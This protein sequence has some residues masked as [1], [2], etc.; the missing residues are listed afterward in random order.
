F[1][2]NG[3][4]NGDYN[5][6]GTDFSFSTGGEHNQVGEPVFVKV[7]STTDETTVGREYDASAWNLALRVASPAINAGENAFA[8]DA[9]GNPLVL[10]PRFYADGTVDIGAHEYQGAAVSIPA[11]PVGAMATAL[12]TSSIRLDWRA[13][14]GATEYVVQRST[15]GINWNTIGTST[16]HSYTDDGLTMNTAYYY[17][18]VAENR[19]GTSAP[20]A[21]IRAL[22][23]APDLE[24]ISGGELVSTT[25][26]HGMDFSLVTGIIRNVGTAEFGAYI[27]D[28]YASVDETI[29]SSDILIGSIPME[30]LAAGASTTVTTSLGTSL[31]AEYGEYSIGWIVRGDS[32]EIGTDNNV[33]V[34]PDRLT[35]ISEIP[36]APTGLTVNV[37]SDADAYL[38]WNS[39]PDAV[40]YVLQYSPDGTGPW[41]QIAS[42]TE[43]SYTLSDLAPGTTSFY[44]I[45][46]RNTSG[47]SAPSLTVSVVA[48]AP[49]ATVAPSVPKNITAT[50]LGTSEIQINWTVSVGA[51][52]YRI[53]RS[54]NGQS[55]W[56]SCG[57]ATTNFFVDSGL[58]SGTGYHY[59]IRAV[60]TVG[61]SAFSQ[62][63]SATTETEV[64]TP[65]ERPSLPTGLKIPSRAF[66]IAEG[67][68]LN[69]AVGSVS[70]IA[71]AVRGDTY[72]Y[73]LTK[74]NEYFSIDAKGKITSIGKCD[75]EVTGSIEIVVQTCVNGVA[76]WSD[77][78]TIQVKDV[79]EAPVDV[80]LIGDDGVV[81]T[82][83]LEEGSLVV[84]TLTATDPDGTPITG[85][86]LSG[87]DAKLFEVVRNGDLFEL[88]T[89]SPLDYENPVSKSGTNRYD[90]EVTA[91]DSGRKSTKAKASVLVTDRT[92]T[93]VDTVTVANT[94]GNAWSVDMVGGNIRIL[95]GRTVLF[96]EPATSFPTL[97]IVG[98]AKK[99]T[100][101]WNL[102][103]WD[104]GTD[105]TIRFDGMGDTDTVKIVGTGANE[106]FRFTS[107]G[108]TIGNTTL[109]L[110]TEILTVEGGDG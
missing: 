7:P 89:K 64:T 2:D 99:D 15:D 82:V 106:T 81:N 58:D 61:V 10:D 74:G 32:E 91:T 49:E 100:L 19:S 107:G 38:T 60:N 70:T 11:I 9:E 110:N 80:G 101:T 55:G 39:V 62:I 83:N 105:T 28:F 50:A 69:S 72:T 66:T 6:L 52:E 54:L 12:N 36:D 59:R 16:V 71:R 26:R 13:V 77:S 53:Q 56:M 27:V 24:A 73:S 88:R 51:S 17:R 86:K 85:Y 31:L 34:I 87:S 98:N 37:G 97:T 108:V 65:A 46:A 76:T 22:T 102:A 92:Y 29:T 18:I 42:P 43:T 40:D 57:T 45:F 30:N 94:A 14:S 35:V 103:S 75:Y 78:F 5:L 33:A 84:G 109:D 47:V 8:T 95:G 90:I 104:T 4:V 3:I 20:S 21:V 68:K 48:P 67:A 93:S 79:N 41:T 25:V 96:S 23:P 44:R 1:S 63:V